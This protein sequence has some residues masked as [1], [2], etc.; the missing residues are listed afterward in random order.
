MGG[1]PVPWQ[2]VVE[3]AGRMI[4]DAVDDVSEPGFGID[5][6]EPGGRC[7]GVEGRCAVAARVGWSADPART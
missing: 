4:G 1:L 6:V 3:L 5:A 2:E 7:Q